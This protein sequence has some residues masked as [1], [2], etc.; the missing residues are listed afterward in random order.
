HLHENVIKA[1]LGDK[2][3]FAAITELNPR[4]A[5]LAVLGKDKE[6][7]D[8]HSFV[9]NYIRMAEAEANWLKSQEN[10]K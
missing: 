5:E 10:N 1:E 9:P 8:L 2:A 4:P 6:S 3:V 7:V